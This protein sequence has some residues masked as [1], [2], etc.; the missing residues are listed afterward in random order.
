[1]KPHTGYLKTE[2]CLNCKTNTIY[3]YTLTG[4]HIWAFKDENV[5]REQ[6]GIA[7]DKNMN[8]Y[9]AGKGTNN[10]VVVSPDAINL[11][12]GSKYTM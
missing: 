5:I 7:L 2:Q 11:P 3:C 8:V 4:Q 6:M 10:V 1:M 9:V 12:L